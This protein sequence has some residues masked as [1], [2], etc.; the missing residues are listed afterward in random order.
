MDG[1]DAFAGLRTMVDQKSAC[2]CSSPD[3]ALLMSDIS[4]TPWLTINPTP[5]L[6]AQDWGISYCD[7]GRVRSC[8][9]SPRIANLLFIEMVRCGLLLGSSIS[10]TIFVNDP[11][12]V[13]LPRFL[14]P[15]ICHVIEADVSAA[16]AC[17]ARGQLSDEEPY[18]AILVSH[19]NAVL[20]RYVLACSCQL[21]SAVVVAA[22][23][24]P[25]F[26]LSLFFGASHRLDT[27]PS[28]GHSQVAGER[29]VL[30][31]DSQGAADARL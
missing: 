21:L 5:H 31:R 26:P 9:D 28:P 10:Q 13:S 18:R 6:T 29:R 1:G 20:D 15:K 27:S 2:Q 4:A 11:P 12:S 24:P 22:P 25:F 8:V 3:L 17:E 30:A 7:L 23:P 19:L 14:P 16:W